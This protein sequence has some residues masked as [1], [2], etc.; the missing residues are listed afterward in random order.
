MKK[1][2]SIA[3]KKNKKPIKKINESKKKL[4]L[5]NDIP[6]DKYSKFFSKLFESREMAHVFHLQVKG[7]NG[8]HAL[9]KALEDYYEDIVELIDDVIEVFQGQYHIVEN[10]QSIDTNKKNNNHIKYFE[11][12][13]QYIKTERKIFNQE[14]THILSLIDDILCLVYKTLYKLKYTK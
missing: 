10:Y 6:K 12:I 5:E 1:Y 2:T 11:D 9:H 3:K 13:A 8:S 4:I 14:D 7:E